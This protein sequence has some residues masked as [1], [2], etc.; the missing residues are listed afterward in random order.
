MDGMWFCVGLVGGGAIAIWAFGIAAK[1]VTRSMLEV[2]T[3]SNDEFAAFAERL[4]NAG[5]KRKKFSE[6]VA[7]EMGK[8]PAPGEVK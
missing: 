4:D 8:T 2:L 3:M 6:R 1:A 5:K 7:E